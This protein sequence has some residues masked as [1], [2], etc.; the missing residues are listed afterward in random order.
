MPR[1]TVSAVPALLKQARTV[2]S[3]LERLAES[4][5]E[6]STTPGV[7]TIEAV[8]ALQGISK[9]LAA[10]VAVVESSL[11]STLRALEE[12][13]ENDADSYAGRILSALR[14]AGHDPHGDPTRPIIDGRVYV[15]IEALR[16]EVRINDR[17]AADLHPASIA[18]EVGRALER[19]TK[20]MT[21]Q[22]EFLAALERAY[23]EELA[24]GGNARG[25]QVKVADV[26]YRL[27]LQ[28]QSKT[29][30]RDP[31]QA[32]FKEYPLEVFRAELHSAL[33]NVAPLES[34]SILRVAS[35]S[36]TAG[37]I[38]MLIPSVGRPGYA[39]RLWFEEGSS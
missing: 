8:P 10:K 28:R 24:S 27:M 3:Q 22:K 6:L 15:T 16:P 26:H 1:E 37:A 11:V 29:F 32:G 21:P 34:G 33:S 14:E 25:A 36:D 30:R 2:S 23:N 18:R 20:L 13:V 17:T 5:A 4:C 38:F 31:R 12:K 19:V 39:G 35:G 9:D 7:E